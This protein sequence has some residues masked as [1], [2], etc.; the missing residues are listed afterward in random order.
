[1]FAYGRKADTD[2]SMAEPRIWAR[3]GSAARYR[4]PTRTFRLSFPRQPGTLQVSVREG[5]QDERRNSATDE[6]GWLQLPCYVIFGDDSTITCF[7]AFF[8]YLYLDT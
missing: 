8:S 5:S 4:I 7:T 1:M 2:G 6:G 3:T